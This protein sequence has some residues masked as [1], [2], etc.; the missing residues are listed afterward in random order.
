[1]R[2]PQYDN[3][4]NAFPRA[5]YPGVPDAKDAEVILLGAGENV[6]GKDLRL[7]TRRAPSVISG[8]VV[9]ADGQPVANAGITF[10]DVTYHDAGMDHGM[11]TDEQ[12]YFTIKGYVGQTFVIAARSDQRFID[13]SKERSQPVRLTLA[14]PTEFVKIV[15]TRLR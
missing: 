14:N 15:I 11:S 12:G 3:P 2:F 13:F 1:M 8:K 7:S 5:F 4:T 6:R 10:R 9:W